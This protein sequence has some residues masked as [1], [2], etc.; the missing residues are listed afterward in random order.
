V[1]RAGPAPVGD[2]RDQLLRWLLRKLL[3]SWGY[4]A[5]RVVFTG[6]GFGANKSL[7]IFAT[8]G[9]IGWPGICGCANVQWVMGARL[10]FSGPVHARRA[11]A[12]GDSG[13]RSGSSWRTRMED[14]LRGRFEG[15]GE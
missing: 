7:P 6:A 8:L 15:R 11:A 2:R 3:R 4:D 13:S 12:D 5:A 1:G 9:S 14:W 10:F